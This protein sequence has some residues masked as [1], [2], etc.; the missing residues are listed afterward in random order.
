MLYLASALAPML[1]VVR[2]RVAYPVRPLCFLFGPFSS[3]RPPFI[4]TFLVLLRSFVLFFAV[5][6]SAPQILVTSRSDIVHTT[7]EWGGADSDGRRGLVLVDPLEREP[8][9]CSAVP[10]PLAR[11]F[12]SGADTHHTVAQ[13]RLDPPSLSENDS[14]GGAIES[15]ERGGCSRPVMRERA[16]DG[17]GKRV[18][19]GAGMVSLYCASFISMTLEARM[20]LMRDGTPKPIALSRASALLRRPVPLLSGLP[21]RAIEERRGR[22]VVVREG[23]NC[24]L[25]CSGKSLSLGCLA[26]GCNW[27]R[28]A[29]LWMSTRTAAVQAPDGRLPAS[30]PGRDLYRATA[31]DQFPPLRLHAYKIVQLYLHLRQSLILPIITQSV[32]IQAISDARLPFTSLPALGLSRALHATAGAKEWPRTGRKARAPARVCVHGAFP[33]FFQSMLS[34]APEALGWAE[35]HRDST[36]VA[37]R[38]VRLVVC[39][40]HGRALR[41]SLVWV[42]VRALLDPHKALDIDLR[43][44]GIHMR[45]STIALETRGGIR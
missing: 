6:L 39:G 13:A 37:L 11:C 34:S 8:C 40:E 1:S 31:G 29:M 30:S 16:Q 3:F 41:G 35:Q 42:Q 5:P 24:P 20:P 18:R 15:C 45:W 43:R 7:C 2:H 33:L 36:P 32:Q 26:R 21:V 10:P 4:L 12:S 9:A 14:W 19:S 17:S 28:S 27:I 38:S 23:A 22:G 44:G 25:A